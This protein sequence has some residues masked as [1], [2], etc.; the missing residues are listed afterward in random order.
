MVIAHSPI[1]DQLHRLRREAE[2]R[3]AQEYAQRVGLPYLNLDEVSIE[4]DAL[5]LIPEDDARHERIAAF[6]HRG[7]QLYVAARFPDE[8]EAQRIMQR[9]EAYKM[10]A[11]IYVVSQSSLERAWKEYKYV[12]RAS[13]PL[14]GK[15][16]IEAQ[17]VEDLTRTLHTIEHINDAIIHFDAVHNPVVQIVEIIIAGALANGASD[18]HF[19]V[20][21]HDVRVRFRLDGRLHD[22]TKLDRHAYDRVLSR[23]KLLSGLKLN[24]TT[25]AQDGRF[26]IE[27]KSKEIEMRVSS[28]PSEFGETVVMRILDP[29][30][31]KLTLHD[32][33]LRQDDLEII[34]EQIR[35]PEGMILNTGPTGSGKTTTLYTFL[36]AIQNPELKIITIEDPIEYHIEGV[37]QTQVHEGSDYTFASGLRS[38][39][40]QD[41]DVIL[42]GEVRD[43]ETAGIS[44]QAALT[45]HLV[46]S[47]VHANSAAGAI[48]R[49]LDL[50]IKPA[51]I[52]PALN[53]VIAQRLVRRLCEYCR[54][55][56][57][58]TPDLESRIAG[59]IKHLP[60]RVAEDNY[61]KIT[62]YT[63]KGCEKCNNTGYKGRV[64]VFELFLID[65][66][67]EEMITKETSEAPLYHYAIEKQGMVTMQQDGI[68]K[69]LRGLTTFNEVASVTGHL[70]L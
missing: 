47:T 10:L 60:R 17:F 46:L 69:V 58:L 32:L 16:P 24:I 65:D 12:T 13:V 35:E 52:G 14:S 68:L 59:F 33:G 53:L 42:V 6:K 40:R 54:I 38:I 18:I 62:L 25:E 9:I 27:L 44:I 11:Q 67:V 21:E 45:G 28:I 39:M 2:E 49:L 41:P 48:P 20:E 23:L 31:I 1:D 29:D 4:I 61:K 55:P 64:G 3:E 63:T 57:V 5:K 30:T 26:S 7:D 66:A 43:E 70:I 36:R 56:D 50:K 8:K 15:L 19:E 51:S 37:E 22:V 34:E